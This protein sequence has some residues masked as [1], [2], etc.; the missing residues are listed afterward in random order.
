MHKGSHSLTSHYYIN[1]IFSR[2]PRPPTIKIHS[3]KHHRSSAGPRTNMASS[4]SRRMAQRHTR[5]AGEGGNI[6][7]RAPFPVPSHTTYRSSS[8][9]EDHEEMTVVMVVNSKT[10]IMAQF[11]RAGERH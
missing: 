4:V 3:R 8:R 7:S 5:N 9:L 6:F 10:L 2:S 11:P 1:I